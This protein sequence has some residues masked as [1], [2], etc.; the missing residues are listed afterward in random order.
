M[1]LNQTM[2][3][4]VCL[5]LS[6]LLLFGTV[7]P[8]FAATNETKERDI[9]AE[10]IASIDLTSKRVEKKVVN[11]L[12]ENMNPS[13]V[14]AEDIL[15]ATDRDVQ[16]AI[17]LIGKVIVDAEGRLEVGTT[18]SADSYALLTDIVNAQD[19]AQKVY[20]TAEKDLATAKANLEAAQKAYEEAVAIAAEGSEEAVAQLEA[21][22]EAVEAAEKAFEAVNSKLV[23]LEEL[24]AS[25]AADTNAWK[26]EAHN[27]L[28]AAGAHLAESNAQLDEV[29]AGL[30]TEN[31]EFVATVEAFQAQ[32]EVFT[33]AV[34]ELA[35]KV[36]VAQEKEDTL[37]ALYAE[38][39]AVLVAYENAMAA[40][41]AE[42]GVTGLTYEDACAI[43]DGLS[44]AVTEAQED[45]RL[46]EV[47]VTDA[48][49]VIDAANKNIEDTNANITTAQ[50]EL[51]AVK[52]LI[53]T[54]VNG[55]EE[56]S[57]VA[58][59]TLAGLVIENQLANGLTV[60]WNAP[61]TE[62][63]D[64]SYGQSE[65]GFYV[66]LNADGTVAARYGYALEDGVVNIYL[67]KSTDVTNYVTYRGA[68]YELDETTMLL[69]V[70]GTFEDTH[71][72]DGK[73]YG[74]VTTG[75]YV[76][77]TWTENRSDVYAHNVVSLTDMAPTALSVSYDKYS[78]DLA[79]LTANADGTY[80][81]E[82]L[83][84]IKLVVYKNADATWSADLY[85][86]GCTKDH[87]CSWKVWNCSFEYVKRDVVIPVAVSYP[88]KTQIEYNGVW[89]DLATAEDGSLYIATPDGNISLVANTN[90]L[91]MVESYAHPY[92]VDCSANV[93]LGYRAGGAA[94]TFFEFGT[95]V[96]VN[97]NTLLALKETVLA[98]YNAELENYL[99]ALEAA[100]TAKTN[101][102]N[103]LAAKREA[104]AAAETK[105]NNA[106]ANFEALTA[107][108][109]A[110]AEKDLGTLANLPKNFEEFITSANID[111]LEDITALV[112]AVT[113]I[114]ND[115]A[116][117]KEKLNAFVTLTQFIPMSD[118]VIPENYEEMNILE[119][120]KFLYEFVKT[121]LGKALL[122]G[123]S[124]QHAYLMAWIDALTA[125]VEVLMAGIE[126]VEEAEK[127]ITSGLEIVYAG[128]ELSDASIEAMIEKIRNE[129][130]SGTVAALTIAVDV[131]EVSDEMVKAINEQL[132]IFRFEAAA[133]KA[134][135]DAAKA[136]LEAIQLQTPGGDA[137]VAASERLEKATE[138]HD[139]LVEKVD[140]LEA[141]LV[142]AEDY[143][144]QA[145]AR[146]EEL[147]AAEDEAT[148][149]AEPGEGDVE[150]PTPEVDYV[151]PTPA[152][153]APTPA[154][155]QPVIIY[156][157]AAPVVEE[158]VEVEA[159]VEEVVENVVANNE[160]PV[161]EIVDIVDEE[162]P[163]AD[164][165]TDI[166]DEE[167][168]LAAN[169]AEEPAVA[170][171]VA[172]V[173]GTATVAAGAGFVFF[174]RKK[175][176]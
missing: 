101:A 59:H 109:G 171:V 110:F 139:A 75:Y 152:P 157:S 17:D 141:S 74:D 150:L 49:A 11:H 25:A 133:A 134:E 63:V 53:N 130:L 167:V 19:S 14:E 76:V 24:V 111:S 35:A 170:P 65:T 116:D 117:A 83:S 161:E 126:V 61:T 85:T 29:L 84:V 162:T 22:K 92:T 124:F 169:K 32:S 135:V 54:V 64:G 18:D 164:G 31:A 93:T 23:V 48:Q 145:Q 147:K 9:I 55:A 104:L 68:E 115:N 138:N 95:K 91:G 1:K 7:T 114:S 132:V 94:D 72:T 12:D 15:A 140:S 50:A 27:A 99:A 154:P 38:Y 66:V 58:V 142:E 102:D 8:V 60:V 131:V 168:P 37:Y 70:A 51:D 153:V 120:A 165:T 106:Q 40:F 73:V 4:I 159:E 98:T 34:N 136:E 151:E 108:N 52:A 118:L 127:T 128:A 3:R 125:K 81:A 30:E 105:Y 10:I 90:L 62:T 119:Y 173:A 121:D 71:S 163:L 44:D 16:E 80:G 78:F 103:D 107:A 137:L 122:D 69:P 129:V 13:M 21:A 77:E 96:D 33:A 67:M 6:A 20:E 88:T 42:H 97:S 112:E 100:E 5:A 158:V 160:T 87:E 41:E 82:V 57:A 156:G 46:A 2:K 123:D 89:Y 148:K 45:V 36:E 39:D 47:A 172:A 113:V 79:S 56:E 166:A 155:Q 144:E 146:Y 26:A 174:R 175:S 149:P 176:L 43:M 86:Y 28:A 143:R